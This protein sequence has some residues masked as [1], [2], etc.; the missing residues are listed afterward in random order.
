LFQ[1]KFPIYLAYSRSEQHHFVVKAY[2]YSNG[3]IDPYFFRELPISSLS[4]PNLLQYIEGASLKR[5]LPSKPEVQYSYIL[6]EFAPY[7]DF[8]DIFSRM[9]DIQDEKI[10][11]T[12]FHQLIDGI[13]YLH[14]KGY[15][16]MD[17]KLDNLLLGENYVLKIADFDCSHFENEKVTLQRGTRGYRAPEVKWSRCKN[18]K[19]ADL[20]SAGILLFMLKAG[21][22]PYLEGENVQGVDL[23]ELL[24]TDQ[25]KYF[26]TLKKMRNATFDKDFKKLFLSMVDPEAEKRLSFKDIRRNKWYKGPIYSQ[27]EL[28]SIMEQFIQPTKINNDTPL[29]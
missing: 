21:F 16:H 1:S 9:R 24:M 20:Y 12:Y 11:R 18:P 23:L 7:G 6:M 10:A 13:E 4:H 19:A 2:P 26:E 22:A 29:A 5:G 3:N 27:N 28:K 14:S 25:K 15:A 17:L 8:V